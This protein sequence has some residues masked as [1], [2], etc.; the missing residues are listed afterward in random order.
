[1][2]E[3]NKEDIKETEEEGESER[4]GKKSG[5]YER[6]HESDTWVPNNAKRGERKRAKR[7]TYKK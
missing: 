4:E 7:K 6:E 1:M 3:G 2:K 5:I